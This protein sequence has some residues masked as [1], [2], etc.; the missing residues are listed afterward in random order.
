VGAERDPSKLR[1]HEALEEIQ[2]IPPALQA[3]ASSS[4][5]GLLNVVTRCVCVYL[6]VC[7]CVCLFVCVCWGGGLLQSMMQLAASQIPLLLILPHAPR[8]TNQPTNQPTNPPTPPPTHTHL[9]RRCNEYNLKDYLPVYCANQLVGYAHS[10][11][12]SELTLLQQG[13]DG[14]KWMWVV[15]GALLI[16]VTTQMVPAISFLPSFLPSRAPCAMD[17]RSP[18]PT[19][20]LT[21][22]DT[23][24]QG[25]RVE[26]NSYV[27]LA[28]GADTPEKRTR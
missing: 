4:D 7:I 26:L 15:R 9:S 22:H 13:T 16:F 2:D 12:V 21:A 20:Q 28:P 10:D 18:R 6:C 25:V 24:G 1:A 8:S 19:H 11:F 23:T 3:Q 27:E 17:Y 14:R 5:S